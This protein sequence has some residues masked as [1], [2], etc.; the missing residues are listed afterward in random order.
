MTAAHYI[1]LLLLSTAAEGS[2]EHLEIIEQNGPGIWLALYAEALVEKRES[3]QPLWH[4]SER[5]RVLVDHVLALSLPEQV[6]AWR[7]P[8][9]SS[10]QVWPTR[11]GAPLDAASAHVVPPVTIAIDEDGPPPPIPKRKPIPGIT[12]AAD[13]A[14]RREQVQDLLNRGFGTSEIAQTLEMDHAEVEQIF[15]G[16]A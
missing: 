2:R 4:L 15:F 14:D 10:N 11:T 7:M 8:D 12:P 16:G 5:G 13:P 6:T 1:G 3:E 9:P